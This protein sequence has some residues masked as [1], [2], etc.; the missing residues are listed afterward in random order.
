M[1]IVSYWGNWGMRADFIFLLSLILL[2]TQTLQT[3]RHWTGDFNGHRVL[4]N[5]NQIFFNFRHTPF[6]ASLFHCTSVW[7]SRQYTAYCFKMQN[8]SLL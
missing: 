4:N 6:L 7:M 3:L 8:L 5:S 1:R 2:L